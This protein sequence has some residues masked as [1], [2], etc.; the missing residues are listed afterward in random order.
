M[1]TLRPLLVAA[2]L[3]AATPAFAQSWYAG[4][5]G[6]QSRTGRELVH[7][8]ESTVVDAKEVSSEFDGTDGGWKVFAG[9]R[10]NDLLAIEASYADL[11]T[12]RLVTH[13]VSIDDLVGSIDIHRKITAYGLDAVLSAPIGSQFAVFGRAGAA[14]SRLRA[15]ASLEGG[16]VFTNGPPDQRARSITRDETVAHFGLGGEWRLDRVSVR[17]EWERF[18]DVGKAFRIG[19]TGTTGEADTDLVSL[20][21]LFR[22]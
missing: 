17:L 7:N 12:S 5:A 21:V 10:A 2:A 19:G 9:W 4:A 8:R 11:G 22:F 6:G 3:A 20:G 16:I 15:D 14:R 1:K 18:H 13:T